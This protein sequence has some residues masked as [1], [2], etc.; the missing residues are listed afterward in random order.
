MGENS[1]NGG[2]DWVIQGGGKGETVLY[3]AKEWG[4]LLVV[5]GQP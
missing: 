2:T 1:R 4:N 3:N 5:G